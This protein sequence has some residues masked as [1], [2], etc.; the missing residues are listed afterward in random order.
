MVDYTTN[1][2]LVDKSD[3]QLSSVECLRKSVKWYHKFF[4][5]MVDVSM[6]NAYNIWLVRKDIQPTKKPKLR[7][8]VYSVAYQLREKYGQ[9]TTTL[10][11][12]RPN[13]L[14]DRIMEASVPR[15]Y[16]VHTQMVNGHRLRKECH[17]CKHTA[18]RPQKRTRV[19]I[20]CNECNVGLC[21]GDCFRDYHTLKNF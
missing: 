7:E 14:P 21:M 4:I 11:G 2:R 3:S 5:H 9:P 6:L 8:F 18:K 20:I 19:N 1:M 15:H 12:R 16:P 10:K 13:S 17:V